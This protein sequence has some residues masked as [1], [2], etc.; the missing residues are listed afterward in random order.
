MS[1]YEWSDEELLTLI[2]EINY[3]YLMAPIKR[4]NRQYFQYTSMLGN[5]SKHSAM[6]Q[7]NL[8]KI[9]L[10]LYNRHDQNYVKI[11]EE[12][13]I[14]IKDNFETLLDNYFGQQNCIDLVK[15]YE[16]S[17][18]IEL[19]REFRKKEGNNV[20]LDLFWIQLKLC[21][22]EVSVEI[23]KA[24]IDGLNE[25]KEEIKK[26][27]TTTNEN[28]AIKKKQNDNEVQM[29]QLQPEKNTKKIKTKKL[30]AKEKAQK[31][32]LA[33]EA[34]QRE[35]MQNDNQYD[36]QKK[37]EKLDA[38]SKNEI[39]DYIQG[40]LDINNTVNEEKCNKA[41]D[42][43]ERGKGMCTYVG[44]ISIKGNFY[45]ITP[46]GRI[47][48]QKFE[49]L[50]LTDLDELLPNS[51][52]HNIN[53]YYNFRDENHCRVMRER[54]KD[55][56]LVAI[57]FQLN[58]LQDNVD[59]WGVR[60]QTGY[61]IPGEDWMESG[62]IRFLSDLG[63]Y[64]FILEDQLLD[65]IEANQIV[66]ID[67]D[68]LVEKEK[69]FLKLKGGMCLGP[70]EVKYNAQRD[71]YFVKPQAEKYVLKGYLTED[72]EKVQIVPIYDDNSRGLKS[73]NYYRIKSN[74]K[75]IEQDVVT[76]KELLEAFRD[77]VCSQG[78]SVIYLEG[79]D[80]I[81]ARYGNSLFSGIKISDEIRESRNKR[82]KELLSSEVNLEETYKAVSEVLADLIIKNK[83]NKNTEVLIETM[84]EKK[85]D[86]MDK[87]QNF[88]IIKSR[89]EEARRELQEI[90]EQS[91]EVINEGKQKSILSDSDLDAA[92]NEKLDGEIKEKKDEL[93]KILE[94]LQMAETV[95]EINKRI[96]ELKKETNYYEARK[97]HL[98]N[99]SR[100]LESQFVDLVN[101]Y[102]DRIIDITF[103]GYMSSKLLNAASKWEQSENYKDLNDVVRKINEVKAY[104]CSDT[105]LLDYL[106]STIQQ[107]RPQYNRNV[108]V[109]LYT[110]VLQGFLTVLSGQPG[111]GKTSICNIISK[112]LGLT[113][114]ESNIKDQVDLNINR[115]ISVSVERGWTSK[116]DFVGYYNPLTKAFEENNRRVFEGLKILS[117]EEEKNIHTY[118]FFI[119]LD[120]A[121]LS[122]MEYYWADFMNI[123]D[124]LKDNHTI[125]LGNDHVF[126]IPETLHFLATI[127]N[128]HTTETL[129]P[130][131]VDRA[132]IINLPKVGYSY[133]DKEIDNDSIKQISWD[134]L[135]SL[136]LCYDVEHMTFSNEIQKI[137]DGVKDILAKQDIY[138]SPRADIAM[139]KY[140]MVA[141]KLMEEDEYSNSPDIIALDYAIAQKMLPKISGSGENF[142]I[143]LKQL[144]DF[145]TTNNLL[146]SSD[147]LTRIMD[148]GNRQMKYYQ[149]FS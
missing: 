18:Y 142:E 64:R 31:M 54:F 119:L 91:N 104:D 144:K 83:D 148:R 21:G 145:C 141:S 131:L 55:E 134:S 116:R 108:I 70:Y 17:N 41:A 40:H 79:I 136:F 109:N 73:W 63:I 114:F 121:N 140:W 125:N 6:V 20:N 5:F 38:G 87:L 42:K 147:I 86:L 61:K 22:I 132:W 96:D 25:K 133:S 93:D 69:V 11:I 58:Q 1:Y 12:E 78:N 48:N 88:K 127:N 81:L 66:K 110:C 59:M 102:S 76:D 94:K 68:S 29:E 19:L 39:S 103:D 15:K 67:N 90:Q 4:N 26:K 74:A 47:E 143:W 107:V 139:H 7:R 95:D 130:R 137:Y 24:I 118:P 101:K 111:C 122:P 123:C 46:I 33:L 105:E 10:K 106:V 138:I 128:D 85:P 37:D 8:P 84:L 120:E 34:K 30:T 146:D 72:L 80:D 27:V 126:K 2:K 89:I 32:K 98:Q 115:Y 16:S 3:D 113:C 57:D 23:K 44:L 135:K 62:K 129:S 117:I 97:N 77:N 82:I 56:G 112:T 149:F 99:D 53:M 51:E 60:N 92:I 13:M 14:R 43:A 36:E 100:N 28:A 71:I 52:F 49:A 50:T 9:V 124:D 65:D 35:K 45:N 75:V